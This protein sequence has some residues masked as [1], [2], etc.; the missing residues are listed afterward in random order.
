MSTQIISIGAAP[1]EESCAQVGAA[2]Y[3]ERSIIECLVFMR[4]LKRLFPLAE[5]VPAKF[6]SQTSPHDFGSYREVCVR[7]DDG[8]SEAFDYAYQVEANTPAKW[9]PIAHYEIIWIG[10]RKQFE[11]AVKRG[12]LQEVPEPYGGKLPQLPADRSFSDLTAA[13]PL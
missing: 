12:D 4:M 9:D 5:H 3:E 6:I 7:F 8:N 13:F 2:D 10:R 11:R 1:C